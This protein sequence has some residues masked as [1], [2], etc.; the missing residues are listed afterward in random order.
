MAEFFITLMAGI[1]IGLLIREAKES[2][3]WDRISR[4]L[5]IMKIKLLMK[6]DSG[7][8]NRL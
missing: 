1:S 2:E 5:M 6:L 7:K 3:T 8:K 4:D